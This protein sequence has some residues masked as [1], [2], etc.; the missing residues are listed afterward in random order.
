MPLP[1]VRCLVRVEALRVGVAEDGVSDTLPP[2]IMSVAVIDYNSSRWTKELLEQNREEDPS[3]SVHL[4]EAHWSINNSGQFMYG[5]P[6][7]VRVSW[8]G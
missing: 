2:V 7:S 8:S 5:S 3:F 1:V 6:I 4:H